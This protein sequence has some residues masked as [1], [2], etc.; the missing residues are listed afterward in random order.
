MEKIWHHTFYNALRVAPEEHPVLL[1]EA[2]LNPKANREKMTQVCFPCNHFWNYWTWVAQAI[3]DQNFVWQVSFHSC[4][5]CRN[6]HGFHTVFITKNISI[7][8]TYGNSVN[9]ETSCT[10]K[11]PWKLIPVGSI[12]SAFCIISSLEQSQLW[13]LPCCIKYKWLKGGKHQ[14][15]ADI[16]ENFDTLMVW[17]IHVQ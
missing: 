12:A 1:T 16:S 4:S 3:K 9:P 5:V 13:F 8:K 2:P 7:W 17:A 6:L 14:K 15:Q 11:P 10:E